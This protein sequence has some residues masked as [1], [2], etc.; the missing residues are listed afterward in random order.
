MVASRISDAYPK[1]SVLIIEGGKNNFQNPSIIYPLLFLG[2]LIPTSE[3]TLFYA[4]VPEAALN[5]RQVVVPSGGVLGG[6]SSINL[7]T[8]SRAQ[9]EDFDSWKTQGW[10]AN[11][12][13]PY[14][15]KV[16]TFL[17]AIR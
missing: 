4:G 15:K 14:M 12:L 11:D 8:Y 10:S 1:L 9:R 13:I 5:N 7:L 17:R 6:G 2:N 16:R 3:N